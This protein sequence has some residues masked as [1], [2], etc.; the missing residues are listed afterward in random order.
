MLAAADAWL[1]K[2]SRLVADSSTQRKMT[3]QR[4]QT[5]SN[6]AAGIGKKGKDIAFRCFKMAPTLVA[7]V[8]GSASQALYR[9]KLA[10]R[11][12]ILGTM[13]VSTAPR[14]LYRPSGVSRRT[15]SAPVPTNPRFGA[16]GARARRESCMRTFI[17]S[18]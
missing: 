6:F 5:L 12:A 7:P 2:A 17:V 13:P 4:A 18:V 16:P 10:K 8:R 9:S 14:P 3:H 15:I 1:W 11:M